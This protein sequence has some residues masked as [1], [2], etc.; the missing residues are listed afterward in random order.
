MNT[1]QIVL[2]IVG[3]AL[4]FWMVGAYNRLVRLRA[5]IVRQYPPV[6]EQLVL[7]HH[8]LQRQ[9]EAL[10]PVLISAAARIDTLR[11]A[12]R[13]IEAACEHARAHPG[14]PGAITSLRLA[15]EILSDARARLPVQ[16]VPGL[17]L[18][19]LNTQL[20]ATDATLA[21]ARRQFNDAVLVYN[22]AVAQ[23]PTVLIVGLFG[24]RAAS[25]L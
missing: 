15:D 4:L 5:S 25:T 13:Q 10:T 14:A 19:E 16:S 20:S 8:L 12:C 2:V 18:S 1:L 21:F 11:A 17:D 3:A 22:A 23:F 6:D 7:R 9:I 24:F